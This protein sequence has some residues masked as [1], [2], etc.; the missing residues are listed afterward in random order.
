MDTKTRSNVDST[1]AV[2]RDSKFGWKIARQYSKSLI[3]DSHINLAK[4]DNEVVHN[5]GENVNK[6]MRT[7]E[8]ILDGTT[9]G[10]DV[11]IIVM[12]ANQQRMYTLMT[13]KETSITDLTEAKKP[14]GDKPHSVADAKHV[15]RKV[16]YRP[17]T[18]VYSVGRS[19]R[20]SDK[21]NSPEH[22]IPR[23]AREHV[24]TSNEK[25]I[26]MLS[27]LE[28]KEIKDKD[29]SEQIRLEKEGKILKKEDTAERKKKHLIDEF[30]SPQIV[31]EKRENR[32]DVKLNTIQESTKPVQYNYLTTTSNRK[33][34]EKRHSKTVSSVN[35]TAGI[36]GTSERTGDNEIKKLSPLEKKDNKDEDMKEQIRLEKEESILKKEDTTDGRG[37]RLIHEF[38]SPKIAE[39][40]RKNRSEV[41]LNKT[42]ESIKPKQYN[43]LT[44]SNR[45]QAGR[46]DSKTVSFDND[47]AGMSSTSVANASIVGQTPADHQK[48]H[49]NGLRNHDVGSS[50]R[51]T[52]LLGSGR[53]KFWR[54][55]IVS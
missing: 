10:N 32:S 29:M 8:L 17:P 34:A 44:I 49:A 46:K 23:G 42:D 20:W 15:V 50:G 48:D 13:S 40:K 3:N 11:R 2:G 52:S 53:F 7:K 30:Y 21:A 24:E 4:L 16:P 47:T 9:L 12:D 18:V 1:F 14:I 19:H 55:N 38:Y 27:P 35:D 26:E 22:V 54:K 25:V 39:E 41:K 36:S 28:K 6:I 37:K 51:S 45:K 33:Q 31:E 43:Y 5:V